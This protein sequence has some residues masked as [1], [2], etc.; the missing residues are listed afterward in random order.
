MAFSYSSSNFTC[1]RYTGNEIAF[2]FS[3]K[4]LFYCMELDFLKLGNYRVNITAFHHQAF[5]RRE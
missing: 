3:H 1:H 4:F 2:I 5:E